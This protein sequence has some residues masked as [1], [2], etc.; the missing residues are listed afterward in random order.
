[1][2]VDNRKSGPRNMVHRQMHHGMRVKILQQERHAL[3]S[4]GIFL[5]D[6]IQGCRRGNNSRREQTHCSSLEDHF[7]RHPRGSWPFGRS[8]ESLYPWREQAKQKVAKRKHATS[9]MVPSPLIT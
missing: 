1:M 8:D 6:A 2:N 4:F 5:V 9:V 7:A 3:G